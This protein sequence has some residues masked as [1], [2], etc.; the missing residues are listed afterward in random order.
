MFCFEVKQVL[1]F[2][3]WASSSKSSKTMIFVNEG[4]ATTL[5]NLHIWDGGKKHMVLDLWP[6]NS[7]CNKLMQLQTG[8]MEIHIHLKLE[9]WSPW[10][11]KTLTT[12]TCEWLKFLCMTLRQAMTR[13]TLE[14][15][16][17]VISDEGTSEGRDDISHEC[18]W[19]KDHQHR[20]VWGGDS[21]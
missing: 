10:W 16:L 15:T 19:G 4:A 12:I 9:T 5:C 8:E 21:N 3:S 13:I 11:R 14:L 2:L 18:M 6:I 1:S 17:A 20:H 7:K